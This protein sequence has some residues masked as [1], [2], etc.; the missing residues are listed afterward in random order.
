MRGI[1]LL[2]ALLSCAPAWA[3]TPPDGRALLGLDRFA[4]AAEAFAR[5]GDRSPAH[6]A[7]LIRLGRLDEAETV[8]GGDLAAAADAFALAGDIGRARSLLSAGLADR[9][10][11]VPLLYRLG[12]LDLAA[13]RPLRAVAPLARAAELAPADAAVRV[14][15]IRA[16]TAAGMPVRAAQAAEQARRTGL[17]DAALLAA[18]LAARQAYGDHRG[19]VAAV[20]DHPGLVATDPDLAR[21]LAVSLDAIGAKARAAEARLAAEAVASLPDSAI[22]DVPMGEQARRRAEALMA[23]GDWAAA[24]AAVWQWAQ[25]RPDD[26]AAA[27]ALLRPE[28][29]GR[30]GWAAAF[31]H[32]GTLVARDPDDPARRLRACALHAEPPGNELLVLL[33]AHALDRLV[34]PGDPRAALGRA[35]RGQALE[36]L[37]RLG[38]I[39]D[40]DLAALRVAV[41]RPSGERLDIAV[42]PLT[43]RLR[44]VSRDGGWLAARWDGAELA[45]ISTST[46]GRLRLEWR[47]GRL[48]RLV[49]EGRHPFRADLAADGRVVRLEPA[50]AAGAYE[51]A[52]AL[53]AAWPETDVSGAMWLRLE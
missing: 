30:L 25:L 7:A 47:D 26:G 35:R 3:G 36:R 19:A 46:G 23:A 11:D 24:A 43:G 16:L 6:A 28:V 17:A 4:E 53:I 42:D 50:S 1:V 37:A 18:E 33:H 52:R 12:M 29:A 8:V 14:A 5:V 15:E 31:H 2:M 21:R 27:T 45:E 22:E 39:A 41:E 34:D 48:A 38:R 51:N 40:L 20:E 13:G 32:L 49:R 44:R 9:P 10:D